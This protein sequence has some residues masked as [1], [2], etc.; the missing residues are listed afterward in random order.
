MTSNVSSS[1]HFLIGV[2]SNLQPEQHVPQIIQQLVKRF[3]PILVSRLCYTL[4]FEL[5][6]KNR[7]INFVAYF[8]SVMTPQQ[9]KAYFNHVEEKLGR[10]RSAANRRWVDRPADIDI[11]KVVTSQ[12]WS[13][14][15]C[16][17]APKFCKTLAPYLQGMAQEVVGELCG[18]KAAL[19]DCPYFEVRLEQEFFGAHVYWVGDKISA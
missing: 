19:S 17:E 14:W 3:R 4:P 6:T 7:F 15:L 11:L 2:G 18:K 9:V 16:D 13:D 5:Q 12:N 10:D 1:H 8:E